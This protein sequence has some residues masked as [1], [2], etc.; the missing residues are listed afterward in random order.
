MK[1]WIVML[2]MLSLLTACAQIPEPESAE[3][4]ELSAATSKVQTPKKHLHLFRLPS[5]LPSRQQPRN[6]PPHPRRHL[7]QH[8]PLPPRRL[9]PLRRNPRQHRRQNLPR[10]RSV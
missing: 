10:R 9:L 1:K 6:R 2:A 4:T 5:R 8:L 7:R 3:L